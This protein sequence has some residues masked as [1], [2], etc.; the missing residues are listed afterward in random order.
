MKLF[1]SSGIRGIVGEDITL[2]FGINMGKALASTLTAGSNVCI[3][4]DTRLSRDLVK[5]AMVTGLLS[6]GINVTDLGILP[7]PVL[8]LLTR[9]MGF[10]TGIMVTASHN[11]PEYNGI[12]L[13]NGNTIGYSSIQEEQIETLY[14][15]NAFRNVRWRESGIYKV[16]TDAKYKYF[17]FI[18]KKVPKNNGKNFKVVVD[19]GNGAASG[20]VSELLGILGY[21]VLPIN[22]YP[23]GLFPNREAEPNEET[24]INTIKFLKD[25]RADIAVCFDGDADRVVFCDKEG[26]LGFTEMIAFISRLIVQKTGNCKVITTVETGKLLDYALSDLNVEIIRGKV[27]DVYVG[28]LV[29]EHK[30]CIGVEQVGVYIIPDLSYCP[31]SLYTTLLLLDSINQVKDIRNTFEKWGKLYFGKNKLSCLKNNKH[32][33]MDLIQQK[34]LNDKPLNINT[35]DGLRFEYPDS[36]V[37]IRPSGTEPVIRIIAEANSEVRLKQLL[38]S[39]TGLTAEVIKTVEE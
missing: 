27:G 13:F 28:N 34:Q 24:L 11:P 15:S 35:I 37:L 20:L 36:W 25:N 23:D 19:P 31:E 16:E 26:F 3:A 38:S 8:A 29:N 39:M 32:R 30:A 9:E 21:D 1:G 17:D 5:S 7:T 18:K 4:T 6:S 22:D 10:K 2:D 33:I 14:L 12:K